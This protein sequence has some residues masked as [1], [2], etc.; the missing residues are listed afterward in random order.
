M[1]DV[2]RDGTFFIP[3][4]ETVY[5]GDETMR[6]RSMGWDV[7]SSR[8]YMRMFLTGRFHPRQFSKLV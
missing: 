4:L 2:C 7:F 1:G 8:L 5:M 3:G 6:S